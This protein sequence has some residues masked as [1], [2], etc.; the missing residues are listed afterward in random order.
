MGVSSGASHWISQ[1]LEGIHSERCRSFVALFS[2]LPVAR[3]NRDSV[4]QPPKRLSIRCKR[5]GRSQGL[6][7]LATGCRSNRLRVERLVSDNEVLSTFL[8]VAFQEGGYRVS[9]PVRGLS[10]SGGFQVLAGR[11]MGADGAR[12]VRRSFAPSLVFL[13]VKTSLPAFPDGEP[14]VRFAGRR[15]SIRAPH[16]RSDSCEP[17]REME[18]FDVPKHV[19]SGSLRKAEGALFSVGCLQATPLSP[20]ASREVRG[21]QVAPSGC[22][23]HPSRLR[24]LLSREGVVEKAVR[25]TLRGSFP[26]RSLHLRR[27]GLR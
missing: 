13:V 20:G 17:S 5:L 1:A 14:S 2:L 26:G 3:E 23:S 7:R 11:V 27:G 19:L 24:G 12:V 6:E 21:G 4:Q 8:E 9:R 10:V 18:T 25:I 15:V 22:P 16:L